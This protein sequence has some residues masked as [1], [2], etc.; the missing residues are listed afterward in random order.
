MIA[1]TLAKPL[2]E[3]RKLPVREDIDLNTEPVVKIAG[4]VVILA[5][6]A[7]FIVFW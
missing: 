3:P 6:I 1:I 7:F 2:A 5:V 4:A